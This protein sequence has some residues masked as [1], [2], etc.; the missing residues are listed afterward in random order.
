[1]D[2]PKAIRVNGAV[3]CV[4]VFIERDALNDLHILVEGDSFHGVPILTE[5]DVLDG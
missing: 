1:M 4:P 2:S 3:H 5:T